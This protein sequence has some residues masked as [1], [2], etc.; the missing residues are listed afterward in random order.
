[1]NNNN[2]A[3]NILD[4]KDVK[5]SYAPDYRK[6]LPGVNFDAKCTFCNKN[7]IVKYGM[8]PEEGLCIASQLLCLECP[9]CHKIIAPSNATHIWFSNCRYKMKSKSQGGKVE[10]VDKIATEAVKVSL[11]NNNTDS[12]LTSLN[13]KCYHKF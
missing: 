3:S 4:V 8:P 7:V 6:V 11:D 12:V 9:L 5:Y 2:L 13:V 10:K 1:M